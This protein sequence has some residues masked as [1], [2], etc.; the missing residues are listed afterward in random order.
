MYD[1]KQGNRVDHNTMGI[2]RCHEV[3]YQMDIVKRIRRAATH[4]VACEEKTWKDDRKIKGH[5]SHTLHIYILSQKPL[6]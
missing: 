4:T 5:V 1:N 6:S 3:Y 2:H